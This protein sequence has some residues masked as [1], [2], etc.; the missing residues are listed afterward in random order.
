MI[1]EP[2]PEKMLAGERGPLWAR[3][4]DYGTIVTSVIDLD[5]FLLYQEL[6]LDRP[7]DNK[8][9]KDSNKELMQMLSGEEATVRYRRESAATSERSAQFIRRRPKNGN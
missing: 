3:N 1:P 2:W 8:E 4:P 7:R 9:E 6:G 5:R